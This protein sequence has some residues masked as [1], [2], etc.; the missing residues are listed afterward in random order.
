MFLFLL[1]LVAIG[2]TSTG[3]SAGNIKMP[4]SLPAGIPAI[5]APKDTASRGYSLQTIDRAD[6]EQ[7]RERGLSGRAEIPHEYGLLFV[8]P[9]KGLH[10]F[11]MK[12]MQAPIDI[13]WLSDDGTVLGIEA[14]VTPSTYPKTFSP[15]E[16]VR[17]VLETRAG[18]ARMK[19]WTVSSRL[20]LP[21]R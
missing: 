16:P 10:G 5:E 8:F 18:E 4:I 19:G 20:G 6:S 3:L 15:P 9:E 12:D 14:S 13:I 2:L 1:A 11:W 17:Y 7:E 21:L